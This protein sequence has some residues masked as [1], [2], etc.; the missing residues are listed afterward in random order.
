MLLFEGSYEAPIGDV[1]D[2]EL[3]RPRVALSRK[4]VQMDMTDAQTTSQNKPHGNF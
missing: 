1:Q 4:H 2:L 3:N